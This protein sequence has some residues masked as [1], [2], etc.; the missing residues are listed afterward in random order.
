MTYGGK[1]EKHGRRIR[2]KDDR[3][4]RSAVF[5]KGIDKRVQHIKN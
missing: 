1:D 3:S 5:G 4:N 2:E